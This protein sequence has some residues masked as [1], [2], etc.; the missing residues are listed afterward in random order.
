MTYLNAMEL[1]SRIWMEHQE[2]DFI[3]SLKVD[4][5]LS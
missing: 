3:V 4:S 5:H 2:Y 1:F